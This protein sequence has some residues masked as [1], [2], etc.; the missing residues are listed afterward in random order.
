MNTFIISFIVVDII[1][2][3][4][5]GIAHANVSAKYNEYKDIQIST[6]LTGKEVAERILRENEISEISVG[7]VNGTMTDHYNH[8]K[9]QLN[10]SEEVYNSSTISAVAI[11]AHEAGHAIQYK[12]G[13]FGIRIRNIVIPLCNV[14]SRAFLPLLLIGIIL[15]ATTVATSGTDIGELIVLLSLATL[16]A[17]VLVNLVTLPVEFDASRRALEELQSMQ[18]I[19]EDEIYGVRKMLNAAALTYVAGFVISV[20]YLL[21]YVWILVNIN[22]FEDRN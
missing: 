2:T 20:I 10:L 9:K 19:S 5:A 16:G 22:I 3:I 18:T 11:S 13:Y 4:I 6:H 17:S 15:S 1:A 8:R 12:N 14:V 7:Q 21:R